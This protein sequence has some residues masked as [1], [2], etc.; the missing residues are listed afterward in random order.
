MS[1][2]ITEDYVDDEVTEDA[3][4]LDAWSKKGARDI[5]AEITKDD[6]KVNEDTS[7]LDNLGKK[8]CQIFI[9]RLLCG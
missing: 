4:N 1:A 8:E 3:Y 6:L 5:D 7:K 9:C 2:E